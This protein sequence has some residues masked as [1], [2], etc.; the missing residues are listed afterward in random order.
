LIYVF[1][2]TGRILETQP[3]LADMPVDCAFGDEGLGTLYVSTADG[4]LYQVRDSG[5]RGYAP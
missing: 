1:A 3:L 2:P 5:R 4:Q